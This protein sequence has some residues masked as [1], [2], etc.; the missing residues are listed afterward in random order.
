MK[1]KINNKWTMLL[2]F[3]HCSLFISVA[4]TSCSDKWDEH[5]EAATMSNGSLWQTIS[6]PQGNMKQFARVLEACG[7]D[8]VLDGSQTYTVFA[9]T[10]ETFT[11]HE[12]DSLIALFDREKAAGRRTADNAVVRQFLQNH[13]ALYK[14]PV[15]TLTNDT[16]TMM[17]NKYYVFTHEQLANRRLK[18]VNKLCDNGLLFTLD[19]PLEYFPNIFEYLGMDSETDS[20]YQFFNQFNVYEFNEAKSVPGDII[21]GQTIYL[22]SVSDLTNRVFDLIG[23]IN[24]EDSTYW[25]LCPTNTE[26]NRLVDEYNAYFN[27][28]NN[29]AKRDS[30]VSTNTRL[31]IVGGGIF[32]RSTNSDEALRDSAV[33]TQARSALVRSLLETDPYYVYQ[34]P[35]APGGIFDGAED[36]VCSNGHVLKTDQFNIS[37]YD[38][39][40]QTVKVEAENLQYQDH[41]D[42]AIDPVTI[43]QVTSNNPF[44]GKV[45]GNSFIEVKP[46]TPTSNVIISYD[47][48]GLLSGTKYD[49]YAVFVPS[50]AADTLSVEESKKP[51][52]V[53]SRVRQTDQNGVLSEPPLR[54]AKTTKAQVVDTVKLS[55]VTI[56]TCSYGLDDALVKLDLKSN[57]QE[58]QVSTYSTTLR[59]DC[60][61]FKP[62]E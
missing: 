28:P 32:S 29:V 19:R 41:L 18:S 52:R 26:W 51:C 36:I 43:H 11:A 44:Y 3:I 15:S 13:I 53:I 6:D 31:A 57:V 50:T 27:Y 35:Y 10:D 42:D 12:A 23:L 30:L 4:L 37:K 34:K 62:V 33:S 40:M 45:S 54:N 55:T 59:L 39:F 8:K 48:H 2:F 14:Y 46:S 60:F 24:S 1:V 47:I 17:N 61:I 5:Y 58:T 49:V 9:P 38:T 22:D 21:D 16:L 56:N 7:F 25:M 20:V